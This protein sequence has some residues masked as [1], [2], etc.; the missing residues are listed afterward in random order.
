MVRRILKTKIMSGNTYIMQRRTY[1]TEIAHGS[2][3]VHE[4][5]NGDRYTLTSTKRIKEKQD[6]RVKNVPYEM[7]NTLNLT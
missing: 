3:L 2:F 7:I 5:Y 1:G 4:L 6:L